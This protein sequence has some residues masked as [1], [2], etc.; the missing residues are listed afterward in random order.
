LLS[1]GTPAT[2]IERHVVDDAIREV[3][4]LAVLVVT[5]PHMEPHGASRRRVRRVRRVACGTGDER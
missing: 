5:S 2:G 4:A 1:K 3:E